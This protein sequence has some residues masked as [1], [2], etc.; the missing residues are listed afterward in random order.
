M[1]RSL[2]FSAFVV[3]LVVGCSTKRPVLY[4]NTHLKEV[5]QEQA[6][7]DTQECYSLAK[8]YLK[9]QSGNQAVEDSVKSGTVG[10]A[11]GAAGGA[12]YG[13]AGKGA[14][15]GAAASA[16]RSLLRVRDPSPLFMNYVN[17]C[18]REKGYQPIGW[19]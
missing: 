8:Q 7:R 19:E 10:A 12:V 15:A 5:G 3:L 14:A 1:S 6:D 4:P 13:H 16:T 18:L 11:A 9:S 17:Q 2:V